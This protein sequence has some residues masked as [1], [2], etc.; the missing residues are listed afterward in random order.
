MLKALE[1]AQEAWSR[2][3]GIPEYHAL[4]PSIL[5]QVAVLQG[6]IGR[7]QRA[8]WFLERG[9]VAT[10]GLE[11]LKVQIRRA[12]VLIN[13]GRYAEAEV[14]LSS[15]G[16]QEAPEQYQVERRL[17]LGEIAWARGDLHFAQLEFGEA[18]RFARNFK[19]TYEEFRILLSLV[20]IYILSD[21][22]SLAQEYLKQAQALISDK[23]DRLLFRLREVLLNYRMGFYQSRHAVSEL[24]GLISAFGEMGLLQEQAAAHF[25]KAALLHAELDDGWRRELDEAHAL[26]VSLQNPALLA[27]EWLSAPALHRDAVKLYPRIA[28]EAPSILKIFTLGREEMSLSGKVI[29][30]PLRRGI[31]LLAFLLEHK[32]ISLQQIVA[33]VFS[34]ERPSAAKSYFHQF[35]HQLREALPTVHVEYDPE[36]K[37]YRLKSEI[38]IL[39]DVMELRAGRVKGHVGPFLPTSASSWARDFD[40]ELDRFRKT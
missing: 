25:H 4:A 39:W 33:D 34:N 22:Y 24:D 16:L 18:I 14:E 8:L 36:A 5:A 9:L 20:S 6:R 27:R 31:E 28:G 30:L 10:S 7:A 32:A 19:F 35:R 17:L 2:I 29:H 3:Q 11:R 12:F 1:A 40:K 15:I 26:S 38:N 37:L 13:L 23:S 21:E